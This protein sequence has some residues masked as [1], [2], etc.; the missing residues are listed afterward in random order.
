MSALDT[1]T[2]RVGK[3]RMITGCCTSNSSLVSNTQV[4]LVWRLVG[5]RVVKAG[6]SEA[7]A[8]VGDL[9][10]WMSLV[11]ANTRAIRGLALT[12]QRRGGVD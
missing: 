11:T 5:C 3:L 6:K 2:L 8:S 4:T 10:R 7:R 1:M 12:E 9:G